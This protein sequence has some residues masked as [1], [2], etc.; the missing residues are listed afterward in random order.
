MK[1]FVI[2]TLIG[3]VVGP[4]PIARSLVGG[5][6]GQAVVGIEHPAVLILAMKSEDLT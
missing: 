6:G 5:P 1:R 2:T 4:D 3:L